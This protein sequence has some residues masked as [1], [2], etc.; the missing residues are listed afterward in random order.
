MVKLEV[1][2]LL[3]VGFSRNCSVARIHC[4]LSDL[5]APQ[6]PE[7]VHFLYFVWWVCK[8]SHHS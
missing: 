5:L 3:L 7:G 6:L 2:C 1:V 4:Y 8:E